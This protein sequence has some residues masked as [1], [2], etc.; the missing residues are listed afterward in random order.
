MNRIQYWGLKL[1]FAHCFYRQETK[2]LRVATIVKYSC[3]KKV[4]L[5]A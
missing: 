3:A 2:A 4:S 1:F 5:P